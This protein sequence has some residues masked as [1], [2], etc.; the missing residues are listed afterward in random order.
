MKR[1][2]TLALIFVLAAA[3]FGATSIQAPKGFAGTLYRGTLALYA[4]QGDRTRFLCTTEPFEKIAGGYHLISA[5]HCVQ[6][7][8]ADVKFFVADDIGGPLTPVT[9]LKAH[10]GDDLDFSEFELKTARAYPIFELGDERDMRVGDAVINPNF[11][12]GVV[13]QLGFGTISSGTIP[14]SPKCEVDDCAGYFLVQ[15]YGMGGSSGSA[16]ISD[17]THKV[18]GLVVMGF[19]APIG[20][21]VE[22]ISKFA[23][24]LAE[25]SQPHPTDEDEDQ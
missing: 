12:G 2:L 10:L 18:I 14:V 17:K 21:G 22:P 23:R 13:K 19:G 20:F 11:A 7:V 25:P 1:F 6:L 9:M 5:G 24:F 3:S 4:I 16:V 15:I 8:P